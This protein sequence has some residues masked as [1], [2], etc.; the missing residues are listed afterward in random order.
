MSS[1]SFGQTFRGM[2]RIPN[3]FIPFYP[4][5]NVFPNSLINS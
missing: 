2:D 1:G 5:K 4:I 3:G